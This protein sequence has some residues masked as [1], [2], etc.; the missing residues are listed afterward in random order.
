[1]VCTV[2]T[3]KQ[4]EIRNPFRQIATNKT[5]VGENLM[6]FPE[7]GTKLRQLTDNEPLDVKV[8]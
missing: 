6:A 7:I 4:H 3:V 8:K 2:N 1:M 5:D